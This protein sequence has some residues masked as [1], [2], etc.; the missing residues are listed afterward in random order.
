MERKVQVSCSKVRKFIKIPMLIDYECLEKQFDFQ[1]VFI[2]WYS[3]YYS[4]CG[5]C[6]T[7]YNVTYLSL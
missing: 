5:N 1:L 4:R 7:Y 6:F 2:D 3:N